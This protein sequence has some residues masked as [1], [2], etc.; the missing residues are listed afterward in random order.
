MQCTYLKHNLK[1][2][3][4]LSLVTTKPSEKER[5]GRH[6]KSIKKELKNKTRT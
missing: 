6:L 3:F 5:E 2:N 1:R 4:K